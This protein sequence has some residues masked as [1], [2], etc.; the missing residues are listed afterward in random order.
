MELPVIQQTGPKMLPG[1]EDELHQILTEAVGAAFSAFTAKQ[2]AKRGLR[3]GRISISAIGA[4]QKRAAFLAAGTPY[5]DD[6]SQDENRTA[7]LGTWIHDVLIPLLA[8]FFTSVQDDPDMVVLAHK[9]VVLKALGWEIEGEMDLYVQIGSYAVV[10]DLKTTREWNI[11]RVNLN[12]AW[13][14]EQMQVDGYGVAA[15][16]MNLPVTHTATIHLARDNGIEAINIRPFGSANVQ[17]VFDQV[18][19][20]IKNSKNP[21]WVVTTERGPAKSVVCRGCPFRTTCWGEAVVKAAEKG[22][23]AVV[24]VDDPE[25]ADAARQMR[26]HAMLETYHKNA[27][28]YFRE[29]LANYPRQIVRGPA[30]TFDL[31]DEPGAWKDDIYKMAA[32]RKE[33]ILEAGEKVPRTQNKPTLK[34]TPL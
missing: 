12:G 31:H 3:N 19:E 30:G 16:Q 8:E 6:A 7:N 21:H 23:N 25:A 9:D 1:F 13:P 27:K 14:S 28:E 5:S 11:D 18:K 20:V 15:L 29:V 32:E 24:P 34:A 22:R 10:I 4:C 2:T 26:G 33:Q 17:A